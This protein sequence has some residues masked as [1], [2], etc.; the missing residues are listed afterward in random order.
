MNY[1]F[2]TDSDSD[3]PFALKQELEGSHKL[4]DQPHDIIAL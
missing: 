3:L 4:A 2:M 1:V